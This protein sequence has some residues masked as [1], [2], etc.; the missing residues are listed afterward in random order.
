[1]FLL[2]GDLEMRSITKIGNNE[3]RVMRE[4]MSNISLI[5]Y[6]RTYFVHRMQTPSIH[7]K[8]LSTWF[9]RF[10]QISFQNK[11]GI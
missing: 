10:K 5:L 6:L 7:I 8:Y 2:L 9:D 4:P 3:I 1:M 11:I